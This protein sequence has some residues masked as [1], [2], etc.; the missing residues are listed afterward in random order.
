MKALDPL[1]KFET[2]TVC[3]DELTRL[4]PHFSDASI[5]QTYE[6]GT[7]VWGADK[8][9]IVSLK[10]E[11]EIVSIALFRVEKIRFTGIGVA[12][13]RWGPVWKNK[14]QEDLSVLKNMLRGIFNEFVIRRKLVL[15]IT[16]RIYTDDPDI[17]TLTDIF[18]TEGYAIQESK[19][20]TI[21][22]H[23][24][25][26]LAGIR[27]GLNKKWRYYLNHAEKSG[28]S[29]NINHKN[30]LTVIATIFAEMHERKKFRTSI[31]IKDF[32]NMHAK[33]PNELKINNLI[34]YMDEIPLSFV[35]WSEI[36]DTA[37][38]LF[39]GTTDQAL[40]FNSGYLGWWKVIEHA[41]TNGIKHIDLGGINEATNPGVYRFKKGIGSKN[42]RKVEFIGLFEASTGAI[43]K[44]ISLT[45][46]LIRRKRV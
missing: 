42:G 10:K 14:G 7:E 11:N 35:L 43:N 28:I 34:C 19:D 36:G 39:A 3:H 40:K 5:Y 24:A 23:L 25:E 30:S 31:D 12:Y 2:G 13:T 37:V 1:Y 16:P 20:K 4:L 46:N 17:V 45:L 21:I 27:A 6:Y 26:N 29:V 8:I 32:L 44:I 33:L 38:V 9:T 18:T 41:F 15:K 22:V